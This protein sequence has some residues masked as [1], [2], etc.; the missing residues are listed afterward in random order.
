MLCTGDLLAVVKPCGLSVFLIILYLNLYNLH[1]SMFV[2]AATRELEP[3][4]GNSQG[5]GVCY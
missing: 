1:V 2:V 4:A 5:E 3:D